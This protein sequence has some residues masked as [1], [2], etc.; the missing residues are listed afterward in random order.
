MKKNLRQLD[1]TIAFV[2]FLICCL[3]SF[4]NESEETSQALFT[5]LGN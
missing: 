5:F 1:V 2:I 3:I 4:I